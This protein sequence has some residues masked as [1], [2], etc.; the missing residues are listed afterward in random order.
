VKHF[1][2]KL[3]TA[4]IAE[5]TRKGRKEISAAN[6]NLLFS[7]FFAGVLCDLCG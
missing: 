3:L 1:Q 5:N 2:E 7:A 6:R 4:K